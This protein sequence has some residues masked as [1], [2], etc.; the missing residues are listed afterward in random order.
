M[1]LHI[2][3]YLRSNAAPKTGTLPFF[4][5]ELAYWPGAMIASFKLNQ[6]YFAKENQMKSK[7]FLALPIVFFLLAAGSAWADT[8][9]VKLE[10]NDGSLCVG[11]GVKNDYNFN[12]VFTNNDGIARVDV[13][14][15]NRRVTIYVGGTGAAC[16]RPGDSITIKVKGCGFVSTCPIYGGGC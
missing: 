13:G 2:G 1:N 4:I 6:G 16:V 10:Y 7:M 15:A 9:R 11:C 14:S 12:E 8:I 5:S 3:A